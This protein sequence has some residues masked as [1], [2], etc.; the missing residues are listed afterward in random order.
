MTD[1]GT[2]IVNGVERVVISQLIRSAGVYFTANTWRGKRLFGAKI[3]PSRGVWLEFETDPDGFIG[4]KID[5]RRK[6]AVTDLLRVFGWDVARA[7][8][9]FGD[10][11]TG[12]ISYVAATLKKDAAE[13]LDE[14]YLEIYK[15]V[16]PGD[17]ATI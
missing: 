4:V 11:D 7:E 1:R 16:R 12:S 6:V 15:R 14:S 8:K 9:D 17:L 5:R 3:I 13:N 2:F 10:I